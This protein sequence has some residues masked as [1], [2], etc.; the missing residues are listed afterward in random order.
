MKC[1][2]GINPRTVRNFPIQSTAA[3]IL[4]V[5]CILAERRGI[6]IVAP[7]HDAIMVETAADRAEETSVALDQVMRDAAAMVLRGYQLPT[8]AQIVRSGERFFEERAEEMWKTINRL[9]V[10]LENEQVA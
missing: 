10:K 9:V 3:E 7:V 1:P 8:E 5:A 2:S 4:H 6:E